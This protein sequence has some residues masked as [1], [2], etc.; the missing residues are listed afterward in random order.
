LK[1]RY[2]ARRAWETHPPLGQRV[3]ERVTSTDP[4]GRAMQ[5][6]KFQADESRRA[7]PVSFLHHHR[8]R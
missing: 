2:G 3:A 8:R 4:T 5:V 6:R 1:S 7:Q